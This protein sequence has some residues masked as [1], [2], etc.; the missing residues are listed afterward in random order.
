MNPV[1]AIF[2]LMRAALFSLLED[3]EQVIRMASPEAGP[4]TR[5]A[6]VRRQPEATA[7]LR[8]FFVNHLL[9]LLKLL[10]GYRVVDFQ[11]LSQHEK[12]AFYAAFDETVEG[13]L[14]TFVNRI[15][16]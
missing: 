4:V 13:I 1:Q 2:R 11:A 5:D 3:P 14:K 8:E 16:G 6:L 12:Q 15:G 7:A 9:F 10:N